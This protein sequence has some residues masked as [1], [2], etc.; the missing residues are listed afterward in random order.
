MSY[1][2]ETYLRLPLYL[3]QAGRYLEALGEFKALMDGIEVRVAREM[4]HLDQQKQAHY[5]QLDREMI[6]AKMKLAAKR[7]LKRR[8]SKPRAG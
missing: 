8:G 5:V 6:L 3:Q 7:E 4:R 2:V 1:P